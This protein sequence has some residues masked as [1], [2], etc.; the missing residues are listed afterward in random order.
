M[1]T[2]LV[3]IIIPCFNSDR[4]IAQAVDSA[5]SQS[6]PEKEVIVVD[7]GSSDSTRTILESYESALSA[8]L[9]QENRGAAAARNSGLRR[10]RGEFIQF[11]DSDDLL[12]PDKIELQLNS[13]LCEDVPSDTLY[14]SSWG[15]FHGEI[16]NT[17]F[18]YDDL[19]RNLKPAEFLV[20]SWEKNLMMHPAA[21]LVPRRLIQEAGPWDETLSLNDDGEFF[22]RVVCKAKSIVYVAEAK[23]Y[24]RSD[25]KGSL[26]STKDW[27][28]LYR[29]Y[30]QSISTLL[31]H[32]SSS[33]ARHASATLLKRFIYTSYPDAEAL[34]ERA[35]KQIAD[36]GGTSL[37]S[38][39]GGPLFQAVAAVL[40]W[41]VATRIKKQI[42]ALSHG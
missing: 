15:R 28:S 30:T 26:S 31:A 4:W 29:S 27:D 6:W 20:E 38:P 42:R 33:K 1:G 25:V 24:Y 37:S 41:K 10:A 32:D 13:A 21:W 3:S 8:V 18:L 7:D 14:S 36:L 2:P 22:A 40:G 17:K 35:A 34:R 23:S 39:P 12:S 9:F 5:L 19:Q 16:K 11:L